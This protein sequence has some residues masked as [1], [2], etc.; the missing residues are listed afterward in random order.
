MLKRILEVL[1]LLGCVAMAAA[2]IM[3]SATTTTERTWCAG[4]ASRLV[5]DR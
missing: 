1:V 2:W 3:Q 4:W 5:P